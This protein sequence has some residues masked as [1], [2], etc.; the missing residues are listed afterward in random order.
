[1]LLLVHNQTLIV[2]VLWNCD[3]LRQMVALYQEFARLPWALVGALQ[4]QLSA[5]ACLKCSIVLGEFKA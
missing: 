1:L 3:Q 4:P 2:P 5:A